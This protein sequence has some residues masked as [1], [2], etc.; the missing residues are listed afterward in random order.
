M[1]WGVGWFRGR[2]RKRRRRRRKR[3]RDHKLLE[4]NQIFRFWKVI[5]LKKKQEEVCYVIALVYTLLP[6][7]FRSRGHICR[8]LAKSET[9]A[10]PLWVRMCYTPAVGNP[11]SCYYRGK[12]RLLGVALR[13]RKNCQWGTWDSPFPPREWDDWLFESY[14]VGA[15]E[16]ERTTIS[17][18]LLSV[19]YLPWFPQSENLGNRI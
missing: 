7:D 15:R 4:G 17:W 3:R 6:F 16:R 14:K 10:W 18:R 8:D 9:G 2:R 12:D 5:N 19:Q 13:D 1:T 11:L